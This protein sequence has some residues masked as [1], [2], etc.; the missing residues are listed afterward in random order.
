MAVARAV[1]APREL[2]ELRVVRQVPRACR[3]PMV[4]VA[5][6]VKAEPRAKAEPRD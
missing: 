6:R 1:R 3:V 5:R 4:L 2:V